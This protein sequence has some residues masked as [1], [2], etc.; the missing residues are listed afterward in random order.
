MNRHLTAIAATALICGAALNQACTMEKKNQNPFLEPYTTEFEIPPFDQIS[1]E[2]YLPALE[3]GINEQKKEID[4]IVNNPETPTF[5]NTILALDK[6]GETLSKVCYVFFAL[7]ESNNDDEMAKI[8]ETFYPMYQAH[9]DEVSMNDKLFQRIKALYDNR[10]NVDYTGPQRLAIEK[11][12]DNFVHNGALLNDS[13]KTILKDLNGKLADLYQKFNKNLLAA[14]NAFEI[15]V[16]NEAQLSGI[17]ASVVAVAAEEAKSRNLE[18]KWVFTLHA[19]SRL[20]VLQ[21]AD[22]RD[23]REQMYKGYTTLA[24]SGEYSNYPVIAEIVKLRAQKAALLGFDNYAAYMTSNVMAKTVDAAEGLLMQIWAPAIA[25]VKEE[26]AE[27]QALSNKEGNTF[28]IAPWDYYYYAEKVRKD[29]YALDEDVVRQYFHVDSVRNGIFTMANRL[30]GITFTELPDAPKYDPSVT[31]YEVKDAEGKHVAVFMTDYFT[32][33][34]K[35]QGAWM[36]EFKGSY[37]AEDGTAVRPIIYNVCNFSKPTAES[38]SLLSIDDVETMFHEFGHGLHGMLSRAQ[39]KSQAGTNVDRDFVELPSQ[40]HEHWAMEPELL[41]AFAHHYET[42]EVIPDEL[43]AKLQQASTHNQGFATTELA[44][45][46][47]L[48]LQWGKLND[49]DNIDIEAFEKEVAK[50]L[51]MPAEVAYRYR[52]PFFK[53]I[54]GSEG[55]ASGYYTYLWAEVLDADGFELFAEKGIFDP[56]TAKS[57]KENILEMGGSADPMALYIKF[58]GQAPNADALL[59]NRGLIK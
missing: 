18:G 26:V 13:T 31:V 49:T 17:P 39:Y 11:S 43:I 41:K 55:Y 51:N 6:S 38:P 25:R 35:R 54:F 33:A 46:A 12:Y 30:Y 29:K 10:D 20:P 14:T 50:K 32:R 4:A 42:G 23:L 1:H 22:C 24:S 36:S 15:V 37:I 27:M 40:I 2:H 19:P 28:T 48:D 9:S 58:R 56:E 16:D 5:E 52:S 45:A 21:Y 44:G 3:A 7:D 59:R 47:L 57:F 53:H 34:S 8:G